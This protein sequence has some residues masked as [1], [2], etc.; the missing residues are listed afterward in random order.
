VCETVAGWSESFS[1]FAAGFASRFP[2]VESRRRMVFYLRGLLSEAERKNG[3]TL[4]EVAGDAGP[5]GMQR[6]LN[7][8]AWDVDGVRDDV[9]SAVV[10]CWVRAGRASLRSM[11]PDF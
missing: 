6:L 5:Q 4:A 10:G 2:R 7:A 3:W 8:Y 1:V 9:R 11:T